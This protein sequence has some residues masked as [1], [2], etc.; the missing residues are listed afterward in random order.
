MGYLL[1]L[2][3]VVVVTVVTSLGWVNSTHSGFF[4]PVVTSNSMVE[5]AAHSDPP[6]EQNSVNSRVKVV[7]SEAT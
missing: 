7:E 1:P 5:P 6:F 3:K 4:S 2:S